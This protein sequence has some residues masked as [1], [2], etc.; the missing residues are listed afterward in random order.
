MRCAL[1]RTTV[2]LQAARDGNLLHVHGVI[3]HRAAEQDIPAA[4]QDTRIVR[5]L[6]SDGALRLGP[7]GQ[8]TVTRR[9]K[10]AMGGAA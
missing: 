3:M 9:A 5:R 8:I 1:P 10:R 4:E 6:I 2:L 7:D